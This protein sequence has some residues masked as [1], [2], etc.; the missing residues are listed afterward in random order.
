MVVLLFDKAGT[1]PLD[2]FQFM[3]I[4][5]LVG[6]H[7]E[8]LYS[9]LE[10]TRTVKACSRNFSRQ[11]WMFLWS[12]PSTLF[13]SDVIDW[14]CL[15]HFRS[16]LRMTPRYLV[17][18]TWSNIKA[19]RVYKL[20]DVPNGTWIIIIIISYTGHGCIVLQL[21][22]MAIHNMPAIHRWLCGWNIN[23]SPVVSQDGWH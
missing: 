19:A 14:I 16:S 22:Y 11:W 17:S 23:G 18:W 9:S 12:S 3:N 13:A 4:V 2:H 1:R 20:V 8:V 21:L 7:T 6:S 5:D 10:W 15:P